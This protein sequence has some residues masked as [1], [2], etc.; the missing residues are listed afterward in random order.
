MHKNRN[1]GFLFLVFCV[2]LVIGLT[3]F[4]TEEKSIEEKL[5]I[6]VSADTSGFV[7]NY[8]QNKRYLKNAEVEDFIEKYSILDC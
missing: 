1:I 7:I 2:C 4:N 3:N 8:M 5:R 6:G